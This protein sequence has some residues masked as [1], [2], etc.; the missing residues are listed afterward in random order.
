[1]AFS[2][3][4]VLV[5]VTAVVLGFVLWIVP[6][7]AATQDRACANDVKQFCSDVQPGRSNVMQCLKE[8]QAD[9]SAACKDRLQAAQTRAQET[10]QACQSDAAKFCADVSPGRGGMAKCLRQHE[11]ELS[12]ECKASLPQAK[13]R[14]TPQQ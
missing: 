6:A 3:K 7:M 1:M 14:R 8:H 2:Q 11:S 13:P 12:A 9:L 4:A 10:R 5:V